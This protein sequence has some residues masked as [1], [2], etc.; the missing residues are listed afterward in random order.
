MK[1]RERMRLRAV[2]LAKK[3]FDSR[4]RLYSSEI[5]DLMLW[6]YRRGRRLQKKFDETWQEQIEIE[7]GEAE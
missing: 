5:V 6:A 2:R 3:T 4:G 1:A 7:R